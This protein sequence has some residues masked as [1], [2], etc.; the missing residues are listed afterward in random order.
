[1]IAS[2]ATKAQL[3]LA[4]GADWVHDRSRDANWAKAVYLATDRT[5]VDMVVDNVGAATFPSSLRALRT[6]GRL[7]TVGG[8]AGYE[9]TV[10]V[11]LL[12]GKH[13]SIIGSTMGSQEDYRRVMALVFGGKLK[14]LVDTVYPMT[15][16]R[17]A[18]ARMMDNQQFGKILIQIQ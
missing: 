6:G 15:E 11:N 3:A 1:M 17:T 18:V 9:A 5:G 4:Q 12:F 2:S 16:F 8:T 10:P 14:P 7:V 13:L